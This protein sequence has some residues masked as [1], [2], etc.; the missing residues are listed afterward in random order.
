MSVT[1][2]NQ[3]C[4]RIFASVDVVGST[5]F[6]TRMSS[7]SGDGIR[8]NPW[9]RIYEAFFEDFPSLVESQCAEFKG[10]IAEV[11]KGTSPLRVWKFVGDEILFVAEL[12]KHQDAVGHVLSVKR[13]IEKYQDELD[14]PGLSLKA[15]FWGAGFPVYNKRV[16]T[17][18]GKHKFED[19][20]GPH[21]DL[22]FRLAQHAT[23]RFSPVS[24]DIAMF[25]LAAKGQHADIKDPDLR[26]R[27]SG[28][29]YL[30][31]INAGKPCPLMLVPARD[32][33][34][35]REDKLLGANVIQ[36]Q[37]EVRQFLEEFYKENERTFFCRPFIKTDPSAEF[38]KIPQEMEHARRCLELD[39]PD[40]AYARSINR[41][42]AKQGS[43]TPPDLTK[44]KTVPR[45]KRI[46]LHIS[47]DAAKKT[48]ESSARVS[49]KKRTSSK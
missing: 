36:D 8:S 2:D 43:K 6:K 23:P 3:F 17:K 46:D 32:G 40:E 39:D 28:P 16:R 20:L 35:T 18:A 11:C 5:E 4:Y 9:V 42:Q 19:F 41:P 25:L 44:V 24:T 34:P 31:G 37:G 1:D 29:V 26:L 48:L 12:S 22:G 45:G 30:K 10:K 21:V 27:Y 7:T 33:E 14:K 13:A 38:N 49:K 47:E 15:T